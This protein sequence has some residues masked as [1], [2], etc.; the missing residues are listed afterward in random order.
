MA[1][2]EHWLSVFHE[3][4]S[5]LDVNKDTIYRLLETKNFPEHKAGRLLRFRISEVDDWVRADGEKKVVKKT[6]AGK[7]KRVA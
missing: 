2:A 7:R 6:A 3:V 1:T 4:F 5:H